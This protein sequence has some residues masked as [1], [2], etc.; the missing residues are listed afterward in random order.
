MLSR[1]VCGNKGEGRLHKGGA[2]RIMGLRLPHKGGVASTT[3]LRLPYK[4]G[5]HMNKVDQEG[6]RE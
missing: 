4:G 3:G 1:D 5:G 2:G 6:C